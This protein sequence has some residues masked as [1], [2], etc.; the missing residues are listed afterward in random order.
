MVLSAMAF[1]QT[2]GTTTLLVTKINISD[3]ESETTT[4]GWPTSNTDTAE[5]SSCVTKSPPKLFD[6]TY[7]PSADITS[8]GAGDSYNVLSLVSRCCKPGTGQ[9]DSP[10]SGR[11][12]DRFP[13]AHKM[14]L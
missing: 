1:K 7:N 9:N 6:K 11:H 5:P 14:K 12:L 10:E 3:E 8:G 2:V 13:A 4:A